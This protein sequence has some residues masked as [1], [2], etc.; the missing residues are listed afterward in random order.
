MWKIRSEEGNALS[1]N[2]YFKHTLTDYGITH[3]NE[4]NKH[5]FFYY[6]I[7]R[8]AI[9]RVFYPPM[10]SICVGGFDNKHEFT[11]FF[12][13]KFLHSQIFFPL[14][15]KTSAIIRILSSKHG[16]INLKRKRVRFSLL[17]TTS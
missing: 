5:Q 17:K 12:S 4:G 13:T 8:N 9:L 3:L 14:L 16:T 10:A 11:V 7:H 6:A 1:K 15:F 2:L